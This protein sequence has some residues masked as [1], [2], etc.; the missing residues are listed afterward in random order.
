MHLTLQ[1]ETQTSQLAT[2][3]A[4]ILKPGDVVCITGEL[5]AGKTSFC[6]ALIRKLT[7]DPDLEVP[8]PT[9]LICLDYPLPGG[10]KLFH[11]DLYRLEDPC[12]LDELGLEHHTQNAITLIEWPEIATEFLPQKRLEINIGW[13]NPDQ[14]DQ[15]KFAFNAHPA[16]L[17]KCRRSLKIRAF[18]DVAWGS[19]T[20]RTPF[21]ADA[22][23]R[24][25]EW[26]RLENECRILMDAPRVA[27]GPALKNGKPYS[28][29]AHLAEDVMPFIAIAKMIAGKGFR[30]P[31]IY[32]YDLA[33]GLVLLENL[34]N[35]KIIDNQGTPIPERYIACGEMLAHFHCQ[36]WSSDY[37]LSSGEIY[38]VPE[39]DIEAMQ[40]E[41]SLLTDWYLNEQALPTTLAQAKSDFD[42]IWEPLIK[43]A[44]QF[45]KS[46]VMRD[47]HS[48]NIIWRSEQ[49]GSGRIGLL[50]FQDGLK[51]PA[52]YDVV[53]LA[54][55]A[56]T[57]PSPALEQAI[58]EQYIH[59]R[60]QIQPHFN[61]EQFM[62]EYA[63][64]GAQRAS[65]ILGIFVRLDQR[66]GK[67]QYR[68]LLKPMLELLSR[69]LGT[70]TLAP[71]RDWCN[72][73]LFPQQG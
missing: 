60:R 56:R 36:D 13:G 5:G 32:D 19:G 34:G 61:P 71:Y 52:A 15:R 59:T 37:Q 11:Y 7:Q 14:T 65:K 57:H 9:Y 25:Y 40:I 33:E 18:L 73:Y 38:S 53:S 21:S 3:I 31:D 22:S 72:R 4:L 10:K 62:E 58:I 8:S 69:N 35:K 1:N 46:L 54:Q 12:E 20:C 2:D 42:A 27:D 43:E 70:P 66:D 23:S 51:G 48:P 26:V 49:T 30:T 55:D 28:Q 67:P 17:D 47:F 24:D 29:I 64:M 16:L 41:V 6:R 39:Y 44:Q 45:E 50:D 63:V 68:K